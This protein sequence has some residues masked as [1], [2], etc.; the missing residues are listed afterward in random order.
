[1][2]RTCFILPGGKIMIEKDALLSQ[3]M[4]IILRVLLFAYCFDGELFVKG[5]FKDLL[6]EQKL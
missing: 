1:M 6:K 2:C 5:G 4:Q 3:Q